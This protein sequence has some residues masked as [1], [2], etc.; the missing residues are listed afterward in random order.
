M[1]DALSPGM[2]V[3][4]T[5]EVERLL[6]RGGMGEVWLAR[7]LRLAGKQVAIKV[8]HTQGELP[9]EALARFRRE[10]EIAARLE[11]PNIVQVIDFNN[12]PSGQPFIVMELLKGESLAA[13]LKRGPMSPDEVSQVMR[14]VGSA[15][16]AAHGASV[17][18]RDLKPENIFLVPTGLG[19]QVKVLDFGISKLSDG[20]TMQTT[21]SVLMGTPLYMS[22]EQALGHNRDVTPASDVFSLGSIAY[23]CLTGQA[24]FAA[25]SIAKVVFRIAYEPHPPLLT[26][27]PHVPAPMAQAVEH[28]LQ[29]D[30]AHRTP[31]VASF[32]LELTGQVL[33]STTSGAHASRPSGVVLQPGAAVDERMMADATV[34]PSQVLA[35]KPVLATPNPSPSLPVAPPPGPPPAAVGAAPS[36]P[37]ATSP[38]KLVAGGLVVVGIAVGT[39]FVAKA[40]DGTTGKQAVDAGA[41]VVVT[42]PPV[43]PPP[44]VVAV[45]DAGPAD[46]PDGG[47]T[48]EPDAGAEPPGKPTVK[49]AK[50]LA[51]P[52]P[53]EKAVLD[54]LEGQLQRGEFDE[55]W[56][57]RS[58]TRYAFTSPEARRDFAIALT[59]VACKRGDLT[60][61]NSY[62]RQLASAAAKDVARRRCR[63]HRADFALE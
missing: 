56:K 35:K 25:D 26:V 46:P 61:A 10:A 7:H 8:L 60:I 27:A 53:A 4:E 18:H 40:L 33:T 32:V 17:I 14:Q 5:F 28:A 30:R 20:G 37:G 22:P 48:P 6:G 59:E 9:A 54:E 31:D 38:V 63:K 41:T 36:T 13:R 11:H 57:R 15:L 23:E 34:S 50:A 19:D 45:V 49:P 51:P 21:D 1:A 3:A 42:P 39:F 12:L 43:D 24:P 62:F 52:P 47:P 2:V 16:H 58:S 29:K 44:V 55:V